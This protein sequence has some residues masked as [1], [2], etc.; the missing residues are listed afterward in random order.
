VQANIFKRM[1]PDIKR[2]EWADIINGDSY[3]KLTSLVLQMKSTQLK[4]EVI[5]HKKSLMEA[6]A[7]LYM[8]VSLD[9]K[10]YQKD[11]KAIFNLP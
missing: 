2:S 7:E 3:R 1:I 6:V 4:I 9:E 11:L 8:F 10:R 5:L